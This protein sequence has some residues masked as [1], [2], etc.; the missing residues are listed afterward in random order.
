MWGKISQANLLVVATFSLNLLRRSKLSEDSL[1]PNNLIL[2]VS[3]VVLISD[4]GTPLGINF[5]RDFRFSECWIFYRFM[6]RRP[7]A[8]GENARRCIPARKCINW[9]DNIRN[10][11]KIFHSF[12]DFCYDLKNKS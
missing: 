4:L 10:I 8:D 2:T 6:Y 1:L 11:S 5:W 9:E 7:F 3:P 12:W